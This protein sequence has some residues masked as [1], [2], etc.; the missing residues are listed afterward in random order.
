MKI[1]FGAFFLDVSTRQLTRDGDVVH[2]SPKAFQLLVALASERPRVLSKAVLQQRLWPDTFVDEANLSNLIGEIR[3]ALNE[4][5]RASLSIRTVHGFGY[6]F[7]AQVTAVDDT[8]RRSDVPVAWLDF[9]ERRFLLSPG[10]H[11]IGREPDV[12]IRLDQSSV[13]RRHGR[14]VVTEE[15]TTLEDCDS[16]NGTFRGGQRVTAAVQLADGD[17]VGI[18]SL[19]L[20]FRLRADCA[21]TETHDSRES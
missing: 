15:A 5:P 6:A 21:A 1:R 13:S 11:V 12:D 3:H 18:G 10:E 9:G 8:P 20:I 2:L 17:V 7:S 19:S 14:L 4:P 16:K